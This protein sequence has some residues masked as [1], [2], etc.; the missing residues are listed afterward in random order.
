MRKISD[1]Q[2]RK[3]REI[4]KIKAKLI[5]ES[6]NVCRICGNYGNDAAHLIPKGG[7]YCQYEIEPRNIVIFCRHCHNEYDNNLSFRQKQLD[8]IAQCREFALICDINNYF[9]L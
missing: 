9:Q 3:N 4:A 6:G 5:E 8:L 2:A 7:L 1:K